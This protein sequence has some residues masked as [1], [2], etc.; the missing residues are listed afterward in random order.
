MQHDHVLLLN[1]TIPL[2]AYVDNSFIVEEVE[3]PGVSKQSEVFPFSQTERAPGLLQNK[4]T[5]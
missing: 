2:L 5:I 1:T 3:G 4:S